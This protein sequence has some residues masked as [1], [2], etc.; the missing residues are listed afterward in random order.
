MYA[1][2]N[3][4]NIKFKTEEMQDEYYEIGKIELHKNKECI[5]RSLKEYICNKNVLDGTLIEADWFP[6]IQANVFISHSN[7]DEQLAVSLAGFLYKEFG[8][9]SFIDSYIWGY[10][11]KLLKELDGKYCPLKKDEKGFITS[12]SY[13]SRN[14]TTSHAHMMLSMALLKMIDGT[15]CF[16]F[17]NTSKS[18]TLSDA[19]KDQTL[20]PW[21]YSELAMSKI[22]GR[23]TKEFH[24]DVRVVRA[25]KNFSQNIKIGYDAPLDHLIELNCDDINNWLKNN[26]LLEVESK[27][28]A[29][30]ALDTLYKLKVISVITE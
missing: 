12:Y 15:E 22:I 4:K 30:D 5:Q 8:I 24:R 27:D 16:F 7:N 2:F 20:S 11:N 6:Q 14:I 28:K 29:Y 13:E 10:V 21:I 18:I 23:K 25:Y 3:L 17:L 26:S 1:G 9:N 19:I